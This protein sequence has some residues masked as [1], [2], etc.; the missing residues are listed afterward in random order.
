MKTFVMPDT[1]WLHGVSNG[2]EY[3]L[4]RPSNQMLNFSE[5]TGFAI[6]QF[7]PAVTDDHR[8]LT[9]LMWDFANYRPVPLKNQKARALVHL[10]KRLCDLRTRERDFETTARASDTHEIVEL[11]CKSAAL[12]GKSHKQ[13]LDICALADC[14]RDGVERAYCSWDEWQYIAREMLRLNAPE[15][16][17]DLDS[18]ETVM[19]HVPVKGKKEVAR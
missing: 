9:R 8:L 14:I 1:K 15:T 17:K 13:H 19:K 10:L 18:Y 6:E 5:E 12:E 11:S 7:L 16:F 2:T 3:C 4:G